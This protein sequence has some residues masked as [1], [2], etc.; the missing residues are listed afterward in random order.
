M[1]RL[2]FSGLILLVG[3]Q[4][5]ATGTD[6]TIY[7]KYFGFKIQ[8]VY[9]NDFDQAI[10]L[11]SA[12]SGFE[13]YDPATRN[14]G[15]VELGNMGYAS[16]SELFTPQGYADFD[17]GFHQFDPFLFSADKVKYYYAAHPMT[18]LQYNL[19]SKGEQRLL[20]TNTENIT[21][22]WNIGFDLS[23]LRSAGFYSHQ[24][25]D[26]T[27]LDFFTWYKGKKQHYNVFATFVLNDMQ[28]RENGGVKNDSVFTDPKIFIKTLAPINLDTAE[29][30]LRSYTCLVQQSW[31]FGSYTDVK[32]ND[33]T[34]FK[35]LI[36]VLRIQ[37]AMSY[38]ASLYRYSDLP[39]DDSFYY[40]PP[41]NNVIT[42][43][44]L[45]F[46]HFSNT[47]GFSILNNEKQFIPAL[48]SNNTFVAMVHT[49]WYSVKQPFI[50]SSFLTLGLQASYFTK[51]IHP[52]SVFY[53]FAGGYDVINFETSIYNLSAGIGFALRDSTS[54][55]NVTGSNYSTP[56]SFLATHFS[57]NYNN[58]L[59]NF[60]VQN[61]QALSIILNI[62]TW[63]TNF[64][65][66][67]Y[68]IK[69][70]IYWGNDALPN[71]LAPSV[72][73][74]VIYVQKNFKFFRK[75]HFNNQ[76]LYQQ[77][78]SQAAYVNLPSFVSRNS[79]YYGNDL[80]KHALHTQIG[81]DV[82]YNTAFYVPAYMP[83]SGQFYLQN[84][85][86]YPTYPVADF[87]VSIRIKTLRAFFKVANAD[88]NVFEPGYFSA[89]HYPMPDLN[90]Q[91]GVN[92]T[93]RN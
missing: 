33:S 75:F 69:N 85:T 83:E 8:Y 25:T 44:S 80:F 59:N 77:V 22:N 2:F 64:T 45:R 19:G 50:D 93:F 26:Y 5:F 1:K 48:F 47:L 87:F 53:D 39:S 73:A 82:N 40:E 29:N 16:Y 17:L 90:F 58:W 63:K 4:V 11:D 72:N 56:P 31:D 36:P 78:L 24:R 84:L 51:T 66:S 74:V 15:T 70:Y 7:K 52:N 61:I 43:D 71:Q 65:V 60:K 13:M 86:Q 6:S 79:F 88:Q 21:R 3:C 30:F 28:V 23:I 55:I 62:P 38:T 20:L 92:W 89:L 32:I 14:F 42:Q 46:K 76:L 41:V 57:S 49:D 9:A 27:N 81:I 91:A 18:Q 34:T 12:L 67:V 37:D 10:S 35:K 54:T 68:N